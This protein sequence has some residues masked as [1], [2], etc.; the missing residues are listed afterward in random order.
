MIVNGYI[1]IQF[2]NI[3]ESILDDNNVSYDDI[4]EHICKYSSLNQ[5]LITVAY[6][7]HIPCLRPYLSNPTCPQTE[8]INDINCGSLFEKF[9][10][11]QMFRY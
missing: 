5:Y 3:L 7:F 1:T 10:Y 9:T 8:S 6:D 4:K 2:T 11:R